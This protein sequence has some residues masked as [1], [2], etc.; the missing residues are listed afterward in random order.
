M[1]FTGE[2]RKL[3]SG[4]IFWLPGPVGRGAEAGRDKFVAGER[5]GPGTRERDDDDDDCAALR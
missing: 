4:I 1:F 3:N 2:A 5:P